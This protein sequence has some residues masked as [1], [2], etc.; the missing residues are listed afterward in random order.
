MK[1]LLSLILAVMMLLPLMSAFS[2]NAA[3]SGSCGASLNWTL[4]GST[5]TIS[6]S[7]AMNNYSYF[8]KAPWYDSR[9]SIKKVVI[10]DGVTTVGN[11]AFYQCSA[12]TDID[13]PS[14][15]LTYIGDEAIR[16]CDSLVTL[17]LPEGL[18]TI[19]LIAIAYNPKLESVYIPDSVSRIRNMAFA[20]CTALKEID[21]PDSC[22]EV[23]G[24]IFSGCTAIEK[25]TLHEGITK[26][27][28]GA[29]E[30]CESLTS[31]NLPTTLLS[32]RSSAFAYCKSLTSITVPESVYSMETD[33]F[34]N[35][36]KL[37]VG[38][39]E[40][41]YAQTYCEKYS[42][43]YELV[44]AHEHSYTRKMTTLPG[45]VTEGEITYTCECGDSYT[46]P[47]PAIGSHAWTDWTVTKEATETEDGEQ[48]RTC[49]RNCGAVETEI[50]PAFG[51]PEPE[52][53]VSADGPNITISGMSDVK[54]VF[55]A[56]GDYDTYGDV[57]ANAVVRL[58]PAKLNSAAE[59]TYT[60]REG[61]YYTVLVR[62]NDGTQTFL[63]QQITVTEPVYAADGLQL[64]VSNLENVKVIRTAYGTYTTVSAIKRA[65]GAR[66]F[67]A[68]HDILGA[69][70]YM[71]QYRKNGTVTVAVQYNDGYTDIY[72]YEVV[73]KVPTMVQEGNT[74]TFGDL[75]GLY[76]IRYAK[77]E[78]STSSEIKKAPG[79]QALKASAIDEN[80]YIKVTLPTAGTY[81]FCVQY[82]DESYNYYTV[83]V[84]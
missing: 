43:A 23:E 76:N 9:A 16:E 79:S 75:D 38:C 48:Q 84:E 69:D 41:S 12:L 55:I 47:Y 27:G 1:K 17:T 31:I 45:C 14:S 64:T 71:V 83:V 73:Q 26:I 33:I 54:D 49:R 36:P 70:S 10:A 30:V 5:L 6:G 28:L 32:I 50:I 68:K 57:K 13:F 62:Y 19:G 21:Y 80:G 56:L 42:V 18:E 58:T 2:L 11:Y 34:S 53:C 4:S 3:T 66:A 78:W 65:E 44:A 52:L 82:S 20:Q 60:L 39:Y 29:F 51:T 59:Y 15:G 22:T 24:Y 8:E 74:V 35:C 63:Y 72:T 67:T 7:G 40:G 77:G 81:T 46:E 25:V 37:T 61:G